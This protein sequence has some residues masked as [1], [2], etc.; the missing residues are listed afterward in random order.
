MEIGAKKERW[1]IEDKFDELL[2]LTME[3]R[4]NQG[5]IIANTYS[6]RLDENDIINIFNRLKC[7]EKIQVDTLCLRSTSDKTI[8]YGQRTLITE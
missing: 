3:L 4:E 1:K 7:D 6:P 2:D 8:E 5:F